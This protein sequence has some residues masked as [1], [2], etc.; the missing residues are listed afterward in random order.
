MLIVKTYKHNGHKY[1]SLTL[2]LGVVTWRSSDVAG[3]KAE[4]GKWKRRTT[5]QMLYL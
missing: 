3:P 4:L 1:S 5:A 2:G